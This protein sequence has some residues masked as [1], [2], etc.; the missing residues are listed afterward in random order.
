MRGRSKVAFVPTLPSTTFPY[1]FPSSLLRWGLEIP[2]VVR[3]PPTDG[4][5][6]AWA[7]SVSSVAEVIR[8]RTPPGL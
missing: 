4:L 3:S 7:S 6:K 2:P 5:G 8:L 1:D